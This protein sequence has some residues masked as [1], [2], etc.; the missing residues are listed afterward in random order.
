M[1]THD[2]LMTDSNEEGV[3]RVKNEDYAFFMESTTIEYVVE[4]HCTLS[5]VGGP[6]DDKGYAIAMEKSCFFLR[7]YIRLIFFFPRFPV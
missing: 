1:K 6:L 5:S 3:Q 4:R 2:D 7:F